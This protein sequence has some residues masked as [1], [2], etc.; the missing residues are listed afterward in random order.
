MQQFGFEAGVERPFFDFADV[1]SGGG[2][3]VDDQGGPV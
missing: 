1:G 2:I 3:D